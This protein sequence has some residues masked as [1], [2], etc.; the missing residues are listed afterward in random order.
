MQ[1]S[2]KRNDAP[3]TR[4]NKA[5]LLGSVQVRLPV[6]GAATG[7]NLLRAFPQTQEDPS[8]H[9]GA[10]EAARPEKVWESPALAAICAAGP[11]SRPWTRS[12]STLSSAPCTLSEGKDPGLKMTSQYSQSPWCKGRRGAKEWPQV[13]EI[14]LFTNYFFSS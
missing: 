13:M 10:G 3:R 12:A 14:H 5:L 1:S 11:T 4:W 6:P 2:P 9:D 8:R 7:G